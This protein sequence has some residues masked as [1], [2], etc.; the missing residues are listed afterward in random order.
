MQDII[1]HLIILQIEY[2]IF[3]LVLLIKWLII[4]WVKLDK[5][6]KFWCTWCLQVYWAGPIV[7][8]V[9]AAAVYTF[10][11]QARKGEDET[12]SYDFW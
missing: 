10:I 2:C 11:F 8:G 4:T 6:R 1:L 9:V 3:N 12:S 5:L 7:G